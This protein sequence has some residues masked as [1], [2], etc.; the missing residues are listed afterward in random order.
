MDNDQSPD[1]SPEAIARQLHELAEQFRRLGENLLTLQ[2]IIEQ[3]QHID[4]QGMI[5]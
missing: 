3:A 1:D 2:A 5:Q 4:N